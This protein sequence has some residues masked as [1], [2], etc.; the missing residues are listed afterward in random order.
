[1]NKLTKA[2]AH[3]WLRWLLVPP[4]AMAACLF[5]GIA[6]GLPCLLMRFESGLV[7]AA[8]ACAAAWVFAAYGM[9]PS[10]RP[11]AATGAFLLGAIAAALLTGNDPTRQGH[12]LLTFVLTVVAGT[13]ALA[14]CIPP[15]TRRR[16]LGPLRNG[17]PLRVASAAIGIT[18]ELVIKGGHAMKANDIGM[19]IRR[20]VKWAG[21][22]AV[23]GIVLVAGLVIARGVVDIVPQECRGLYMRLG[24]Y[25]RTV[26]PGL[27]LKIP[28]IDRIIGVSVRER[29][30]YIQ[31]V[32]AMTEDNVIMKVSLQYTYTVTHPER[33]RLEVSQP[34]AIIR[35]F[36]QGKLRDIV[37]TI[38]MR[39]VMK[40]RGALN[41]NITVALA[42]K[43][44]DFGIHFQLV[45][46][47]GT[48][49]PT[50]V[51]EAIKQRMV[52]EQR[53]V[54]AKEEASQKHIIA[55]ATLYEAQ[56][57]VEAEKYQIE[58]TAKARRESARMLLDELAEHEALGLKYMEFLTAREL[59]PNS[60]WI[61]A[62]G[63]LPQLHLA[64][65]H[66]P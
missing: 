42:A 45:Q 60:K 55:D 26:E 62:G 43:E 9:A 47:Q 64:T 34:D 5:T 59:K 22:L 44:V 48:Y 36:V 32:D 50:E 38:T 29:Q 12:R 66:T 23:L 19:R 16:W 53:T 37:N 46:I 11:H 58:E 56:Q 57:T 4:A 52:M 25:V 21:R 17:A 10:H 13:G 14:V 7:A 41:Q 54:A 1:M 65:E 8:A 49:P 33:Y 35:E 15:A 18:S 20:A 27:Q 61:I 31:H 28:L 3:Y 2:R 6:I 30:G 40:N 63:Q 51:Q 39:D 24:K